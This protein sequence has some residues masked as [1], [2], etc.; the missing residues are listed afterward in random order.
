MKKKECEHIIGVTEGVY[1]KVFFGLIRKRI[2]HFRCQQCDKLIP[3]KELLKDS[4]LGV[5][6]FEN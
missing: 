3:I 4:H 2:P 1:K 5:I 6:E